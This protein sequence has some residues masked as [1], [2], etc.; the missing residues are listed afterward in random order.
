ME[1]DG[2]DGQQAYG[3]VLDEMAEAG[4]EGTELGPYG[5]LPTEPERLTAELSSRGLCLVS[6]F[7][8]IPLARPDSHEKSFKEAMRVA[9][10][11][12]QSGARLIVLA[13]EMSHARMAVAGRVIEERDGMNDR[14]WDSTVVIV[15]R[16]AEACRGL[17]IATAFHHHTGTFVETPLEVEQLCANTDPNLIGLCFDTGHYFYGGGDP[18]E[19]V[20]KYGSRIRHLHLKD[21][22]QAIM[23]TVRQNGVSFL[24]AVRRGVFCE[25]GDGEVDFPRVIEELTNCGYDGWAVVEQDTD[26][27]QP[28]VRPF[29]S[30]V[31][32]RQYLRNVI[33]TD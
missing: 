1:V 28:G 31:R 16:I 19:G 30:A 5:F 25:L 21:V 22:R 10:L 18:V 7:V 4:Y 33:G 12:A 20:Q 23:K 9:S 13:D 26:A 32:S 11:L 15:T 8:P 17:G 6:A 24:D 29:E 14:K 27:S 3:E 2:W